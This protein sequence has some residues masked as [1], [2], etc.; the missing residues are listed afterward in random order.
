[1]YSKLDVHN[2][3]AATALALAALTDGGVDP[4]TSG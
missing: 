4:P 3:A 1:M 2:R